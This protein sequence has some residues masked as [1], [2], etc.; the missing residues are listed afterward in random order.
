MLSW[1]KKEVMLIHTW[2]VQIY[3][4]QP[5]N[6][7]WAFV[8]NKTHTLYSDAL[9]YTT[10]TWYQILLPLPSLSFLFSCLE[11]RL[12]RGVRGRVQKRHFLVL[13]TQ[14]HKIYLY[15]DYLG[16]SKF[17]VNS[18]FW[19]YSTYYGSTIYRVD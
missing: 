13:S 6:S 18:E 14:L 8:D 16:Q 3:R 17:S 4:T 1:S 19:T 7:S 10:V 9:L 11:W 15:Y 5:Q 12:E 2:H